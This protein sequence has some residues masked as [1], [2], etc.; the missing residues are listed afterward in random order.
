MLKNFLDL[1][2]PKNIYCTACGNLIDHTRP[3]SLCDF[4]VREI[5]WC[6]DAQFELR[7]ESKLLYCAIYEGAARDMVLNLKFGD[8]AYIAQDIATLMVERFELLDP[9]A[10]KYDLVCY[11]PMHKNKKAR[12]GYDQAQLIC[13]SFCE[14]TGLPYAGGLLKRT[15][16]TG[17]MSLLSKDERHTNLI[18]AFEADREM[19][20]IKAKETS[21][22]ILLIDDI[23]TTGSTMETCADV[24]ITEGAKEVDFYVFATGS[25]EAG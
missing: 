5:R 12:R 17:T 22:H 11:V 14:L 6:T 4:C 25:A 19:L 23:F 20:S 15:R 10:R 21:P 7:G 9:D 3:Y 13:K 2:Y 16:E 8:A 18:G 24:L 1:I